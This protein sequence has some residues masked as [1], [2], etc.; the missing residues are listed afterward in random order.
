MGNLIPFRQ[1]SKSASASIIG[2]ATTASVGTIGEPIADDGIIEISFTSPPPAEVSAYSLET[3]RRWLGRFYQ[4]Y[5]DIGR[6]T[7]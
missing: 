3:I 1:R 7:E 5:P 2:T 4:R 6:W